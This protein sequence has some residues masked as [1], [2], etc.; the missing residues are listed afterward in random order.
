MQGDKYPYVYVDGIY[1]RGNW[2][3][4][5]ENVAILVAIAVDEDGYREVLGAAEGMKEDK[6]SWISFFQWLKGPGVKLI[7]GDK[8]LAMLEVVGEVFPEATYQRRV[9]HF[10][11][12]VF[13]VVPKSRV[14]T[15]AKIFKATHAQESKRAAREK[16]KAVVA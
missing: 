6:A 15:V 14:K 3:G 7:V 12:N 11:R 2:G 4:K 9:V 13:S 16:A 5:Y 1:L 10:Y 8:C